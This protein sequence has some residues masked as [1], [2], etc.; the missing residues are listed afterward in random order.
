[1]NL[2]SAFK[3]LGVLRSLTNS[4][5]QALVAKQTNMQ[6][7]VF[8]ILVFRVIF[9]LIKIGSAKSTPH[10]ENGLLVT[11]RVLGRLPIMNSAGFGLFLKQHTHL[12][13]TALTWCLPSIC[14][15]ASFI[16]DHKF[17]APK[18]KCLLCSCSII[19]FVN[20]FAFSRIIGCLCAKSTNECFNLPPT[21]N[22]LSLSK[23]GW[24]FNNLLF[25]GRL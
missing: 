6:T 9:F 16:T 19:R 4:M 14:Q 1:M 3:K 13:N 25:L 12:L 24:S 20:L 7:Y 2:F 22:R 23:K 18:C 5:C 11:T 15:Y 21:R 10:F 17:C 8:I